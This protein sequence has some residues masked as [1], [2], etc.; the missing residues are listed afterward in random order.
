[1]GG[2]PPQDAPCTHPKILHTN[3]VRNMEAKKQGASAQ[4]VNTKFKKRYLDKQN[5]LI[6]IYKYLN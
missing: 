2:V 4:L 3:I 5:Q 6:D 1:M